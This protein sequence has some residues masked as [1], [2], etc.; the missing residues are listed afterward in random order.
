[1]QLFPSSFEAILFSLAVLLWVLSEIVGGAIVPWLRRSGEDVKKKDNGSVLV[2]RVLMYASVLVAMFMTIKNIA[3]LP[4]WL[5]YP[6]IVLIVAGVFVRQ[7]AILTLGRFF[8]TAVGVQ[9][10]Q[11]VVDNGLYRYIRHPSYLGVLIIMAGI[12]LALHSWGGILVLLAINGL[13]FG[14]RIHIEEQVLVSE[15]GDNYLQYMKR[16]KRLIPFV[17]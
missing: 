7:W 13:A 5:F 16:T 1:V 4:D 17:F 9:K 10:N 14:Y 12:G 11:K 3:M 15:L 2:I 8:T 6:G